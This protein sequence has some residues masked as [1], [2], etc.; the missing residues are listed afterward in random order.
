MET[1][2]GDAMTM[3][4]FLI[5]VLFTLGSLLGCDQNGVIYDDD[6]TAMPDDDTGDDDTGDDD[7]GDDDT[8]DPCTGYE[9][10]MITPVDGAEDHF[11]EDP[12]V[13][14]RS[15]VPPSEYATLLD[16]HGEPVP[17]MGQEDV[18]DNV[19]YFFDL[20]ANR[21][22]SFE[23]GW[24]CSIE[25]SEH[26]VTLVEIEFATSPIEPVDDDDDYPHDDDDDDDWNDDDDDDDW[27]DDD[28]DEGDDD[29]DA[30]DTEDEN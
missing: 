21:R 28:D 29:V 9:F 8:T 20:R 11:L 6:D 22:Y 7:T 24:F 27:G 16:Q 10:T 18:N 30:A 3:R 25:G 14:Q 13:V 1:L 17:L 4:C 19:A 15:G 12:I 23:A 2:E 26:A 5:T